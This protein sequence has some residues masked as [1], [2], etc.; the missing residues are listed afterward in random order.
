MLSTTRARFGALAA[1]AAVV[2]A[3]LLTATPASAA[4]GTITLANATFTA[5]S[6]G[7]GLDVSGTGFTA[8]T[9]VTVTVTNTE[10]DSVLGTT[11]VTADASGA[12]SDAVLTPT[13]TLVVPAEDEDIVVSATSTDGDTS[14]AVPLD[15]RA[16]RGISANTTSITTADLVNPDG[17]LEIIAS[18]YTPGETVTLTSVYNGEEMEELTY[19]A[20]RNGTVWA[21]LVLNGEAVAGTI[22]FTFTGATSTVSNTIS[23]TVTGD[24]IDGEGDGFGDV[25][26]ATN[27]TAKLPVVSG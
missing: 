6:W 10:D 22:V 27:P 1:A 4:A 20:D 7:A 18:G 9:T 16:M 25:P 15:V 5:G 26:A 14:N 2:A 17:G 12:F 24:T 19:T 11:D 13:S 21:G 8:D 3:G 23:I